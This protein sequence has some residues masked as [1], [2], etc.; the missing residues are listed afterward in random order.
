MCEQLYISYHFYIVYDFNGL[1]NF[2]HGNESLR[3]WFILKVVL[4]SY[5]DN[6]VL[7]GVSLGA[8]KPDSKQVLNRTHVFLQWIRWIFRVCSGKI[9]LLRNGLDWTRK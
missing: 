2:P 3:D 5:C 6:T 9:M 7:T 1:F 4:G 8:V